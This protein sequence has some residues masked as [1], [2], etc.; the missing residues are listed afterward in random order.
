VDLTPEEGELLDG[1][2]ATGVYGETHGE[3]LRAAFMRWSN[4]HVTRVRR[5]KVSFREDGRPEAEQR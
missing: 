5:A 1:L 4:L 3:A 2:I